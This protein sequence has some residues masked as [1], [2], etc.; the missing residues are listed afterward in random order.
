MPTKKPINP[1]LAEAWPPGSRCV[2][3]VGV[4]F[5]VLILQP[6]AIV[7]DF[8]L[9]SYWPLWHF[10]ALLSSFVIGHIM[11]MRILAIAIQEWKNRV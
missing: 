3:Y 8:F 9:L 10:L 7:A 1:L 2:Y 11:T 5:W 4:L 6:I